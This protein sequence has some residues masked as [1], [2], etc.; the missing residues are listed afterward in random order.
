M[1]K[2][3]RKIK[4]DI[5][6]TIL[7]VFCMG[8]HLWPLLAHEVA[9]TLMFI[10]LVIHTKLNWSWYKA[11]A[12]G[13]YTPMRVLIL[14]VAVLLW[15]DMLALLCSSLTISYYV[16]RYLPSP[17]GIS[18]GRNI[19]LAASYWAIVL[20]GIHLG[21]H[22]SKFAS[23][24]TADWH[25]A[26]GKC[27]KAIGLLAAAYGLYSFCQLGWWDYLWLNV[28]FVSIEGLESP[29]IF[30]PTCLCILGSGIW[31]GHYGM[32]ILRRIM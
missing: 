21:L 18:L 20:M 23:K 4:I 16:F 3:R 19:H 11:L 27:L 29:W 14:V 6:L 31:I 26:G 8:M 28:Q 5:L 17:V 25:S 10:C 1:N 15:L 7:L 22:W 24:L 12:K 30:Y 9:G 32:N 2:E 13:R